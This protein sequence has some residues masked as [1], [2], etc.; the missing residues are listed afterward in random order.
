MKKRL[1]NTAFI[2]AIAGLVAGAFY[3]EYTK[4]LGF[5]ATTRL[6]KVHPH[7]LVL[8]MFMFLTVAAFSMS[9]DFGKSK[10]FRRF[11]CF[12]N[13]GV[14]ITAAMLFLRGIY[15]VLYLNSKRL[16]ASI[17][18]ISG[19]GHI[20]LTVGVVFLF[21]ALKEEVTIDKKIS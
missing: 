6:A 19:L 5:T 12:Y 21:L 9:I 14:I 20:A 2:Y 16:D 1:I 4:F 18:G 8:G 11:F 10:Q 3:R 17:S 13:T 7:L 15:E